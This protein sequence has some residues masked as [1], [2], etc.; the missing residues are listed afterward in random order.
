V[1]RKV[2]EEKTIASHENRL[3]IFA[4]TVENSGHNIGPGLFGTI[5]RKI[6]KLLPYPY[7]FLHGVFLK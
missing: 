4:E 1:Y 3:C 6:T 2:Y 7:N 5:N